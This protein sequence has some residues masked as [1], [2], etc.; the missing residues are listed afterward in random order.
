M[1]QVFFSA[2]RDLFLRTSQ[3]STGIGLRTDHCFNEVG[4]WRNGSR[5][6]SMSSREG[7]GRRDTC[8]RVFR[9]VFQAEGIEYTKVSRCEGTLHVQRCNSIVH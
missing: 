1:S 3:S 5:K 9:I 4:A 8:A 7:F 2:F 6:K